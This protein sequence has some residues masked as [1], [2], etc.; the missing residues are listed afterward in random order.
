MFFYNGCTLVKNLLWIYILLHYVHFQLINITRSRSYW[1]LSEDYID[2]MIFLVMTSTYFM[3]ILQIF[4]I[5]LSTSLASQLWGLYWILIG[6]FLK[7]SVPP[8]QLLILIY[9]RGNFV[10][11]HWGCTSIYL[12]L[13][14][15]FRSPPSSMK[16]YKTYPHLRLHTTSISRY[17]T[18]YPTH[19]E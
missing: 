7:L 11:H 9:R 10:D 16:F 4:I 8:F 5:M 3:S 15:P 1:P 18:K 19:Y 6:W 14:F 13:S 12:S 17:S 2:D